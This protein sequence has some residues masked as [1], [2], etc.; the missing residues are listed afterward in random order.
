MKIVLLGTTYN[1]GILAALAVGM[2]LWFAA[3]LASL[4]WFPK[5]FEDEGVVA[6]SAV[7]VATTGWR[8]PALYDVSPDWFVR[9]GPP[10]D[11]QLSILPNWPAH[12]GMLYHWPVGKAA[13]W[14]GPTVFAARLTS[15]LCVVGALACWFLILRG[16]QLSPLRAL[17]VV[18]VAASGIGTVMLAHKVRYESMLAIWIAI[19][20]LV[21]SRIRT[22][23]PA[24][25]FLLGCFCG[26]AIEI[27]LPYLVLIGLLFN[28]L[29][30]LRFRRLGSLVA[31]NGGILVGPLAWCYLRFGQFGRFDV[32][33]MLRANVG[34]CGES[35]RLSYRVE[36]LW[37]IWAGWFRSGVGWGI[38]LEG[39]VLGAAFCSALF[40]AIRF[41]RRGDP[42]GLWI[43]I[44]YLV[45][46]LCVLLGGRTNDNYL[47][48]FV[49]VAYVLCLYCI[50]CICPVAWRRPA[51]WLVG[52]TLLLANVT[53]T[54]AK[55][56][57]SRDSLKAVPS[58]TLTIRECVPAGET[59]LAN[60]TLH[61][62]VP[63]HPLIGALTLDI[64]LLQVKFMDYV[65]HHG[66]RWVVDSNSF[67]HPHVLGAAE[68]IR[69]GLEECFEEVG[70]R[71]Y[72]PAQANSFLKTT[73]GGGGELIILRRK[74]VDGVIE[75]KASTFSHPHGDGH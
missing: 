61:F 66:I 44:P 25:L 21:G 74:G 53:G 64:G 36:E 34:Y 72:P 68:D 16:L 7:N 71:S 18:F 29:I 5:L 47:R 63:E 58:A 35:N 8:W 31:L 19:G 24:S 38:H 37:S 51:F 67:D 15:W 69:R 10:P 30:L 26:F 20:L 54:G 14:L 55:M 43:G 50:P 4:A 39:F 56:W 11:T 41:V 17:L 3:S 23:S 52:S 46:P 65:Q 2:G 28:V 49:P 33:E 12:V 48:A 45:W 27:H 70:R 75:K 57:R 59:I 32:L 40:L 62:I 1:T 60:E 42:A 13:Q 22:P 73:G 6:R 9:Y